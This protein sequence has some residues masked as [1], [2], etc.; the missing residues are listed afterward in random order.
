MMFTSTNNSHHVSVLIAV[1][2][3]CVCVCVC[4]QAYVMSPVDCLEDT[5]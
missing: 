1:V 5:V 4:G 2:C 3:V